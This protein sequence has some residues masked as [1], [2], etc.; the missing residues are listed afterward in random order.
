MAKQYPIEAK[1]V[2]VNNEIVTD[3]EKLSI[4]TEKVR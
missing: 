1:I 3:K 4:K 2:E